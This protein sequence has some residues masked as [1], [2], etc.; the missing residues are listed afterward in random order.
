MK[1]PG[2]KSLILLAAMAVFIC[3]KSWG[4]P[5]QNELTVT[6]TDYDYSI[7]NPEIGVVSGTYTYHFSYK[8]S[9]EG[10]IESIHWNARNFDLWNQDGDKVI[11][12][13][14]G[15][16]TYGVLTGWFNTPALYNGYDPR[17]SYS[18]PDGWLS[19]YMP[20]PMPS[21]GV[22]VEM[23]CK[24]LCK[25][26]MFKIQFLAVFKINANGVQTVEMIKP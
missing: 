18:C 2:F 26:N 22:A 6:V 20:D 21:E 4:Q 12:V 15:H 24:I 10:F 16:D 13:D 5:V 14:S 11:V 7:V 1:M 19:D 23:S 3:I 25:G 9:N 8:L 17:I